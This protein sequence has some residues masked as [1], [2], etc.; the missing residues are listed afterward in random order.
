M[1]GNQKKKSGLLI[2]GILMVLAGVV[3][4]AAHSLG[5]TALFIL[6]F[7]PLFLI[8]AGLARIVGFAVGR[9][10]RSPVGG[11]ILLALGVMLLFGILKSDMTALQI[12]AKYWLVLVF[13]IAAVQL[14]RFYSHRPWDGTPPRL[15]RPVTAVIVL[16]VVTSGIA[17]HFIALKNPNLV[18]AASLPALL[19]GLPAGSSPRSF[20]F[21]DP[22]FVAS[23]LLPAPKITV[24]NAYGAV[25]VTGG[26]SALQATLT[27]AVRAWDEGAA[28]DIANHIKLVVN[29]GSD[30]GHDNMAISAVCDQNDIPFSADIDIQ[31]P[32]G[33]SLNL[34]DSYGALSASHTSGPVSINAQGASVQ[35]NTIQ[36]DVNMTLESSDVHTA[37]I[38]GSLTI[39]GG[40]AVKIA[41]ITGAVDINAAKGDVDLRD[42]QGAVRVTAP[43]C[44]I[45]AQNL[46]ST[47]DLKS[48]HGSIDV[49]HAMA[50][51]VDAPDSDVHA[52]SITG[53][54]KIASSNK[55]IT[56]HSLTG[57]MDVTA[58]RSPVTADGLRGSV[59]VNDS[60][61]SVAIRDFSRN[62][63]IRGDYVPVTLSPSPDLSGDIDVESSYGD[64]KLALPRLSEFQFDGE[65]QGGHVRS[66]GF[67]FVPLN[68]QSAVGLGDSDHLVF[69]QGSGGPK[70]VLKTSYRDIVLEAKN[71]R[72]KPSEGGPAESLLLGEIGERQYA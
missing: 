4:L 49:S 50:L 22:A 47:A 70:I 59:T 2:P 36:G 56:I 60:H 43:E 55:S 44:H 29:R 33:A 35:L 48:G 7:W 10:P 65:S 27:K 37:D 3:V 19:H 57:D 11:A 72:A 21:T 15:F 14:V 54:L 13:I 61:A 30:G 62:I 68:N 1:G 18:S 41:G 58:T 51:S 25:R 16:F 46:S 24:S 40:K 6:R 38:N 5:Q 45:K 12:Y 28:K 67:S 23:P 63:K 71:S 66:R 52:E 20:S 64:I 34:S 8:L 39:S 53:N 32:D 26:S 31:T 42:I 69:S 9:R 17:A